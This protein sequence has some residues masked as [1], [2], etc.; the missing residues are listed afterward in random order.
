MIFINVLI[1]LMLILVLG[2]L[3]FGVYTMYR[4]GEYSLRWSNKAMRLRVLLQA[5]AILVLV[6]GLIWKAN[7]H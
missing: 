5:I 6:V 2:A 7:Q 4:G 3:G 1:V